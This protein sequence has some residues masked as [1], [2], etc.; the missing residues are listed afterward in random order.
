MSIVNDSALGP[1]PLEWILDHLRKADCF[2]F[3]VDS[4]VSAEEGID[5]LAESLGKGD[6]VRAYTAQA[7]NGTGQHRHG[8]YTH[9][10]RVCMDRAHQLNLFVSYV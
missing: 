7:M 1:R 9:T 3:D 8:T 5:V 6:A 2:C 10:L 4:T